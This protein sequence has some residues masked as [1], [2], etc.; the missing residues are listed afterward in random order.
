[1]NSLGKI[2]FSFGVKSTVQYYHSS[3]LMNLQ[4]V[5][6]QDE[7]CYHCTYSNYTDRRTNKKNDFS[8]IS[9]RLTCSR[10]EK[11]KKSHLEWKR[12]GV[13]QSLVGCFDMKYLIFNF[14]FIIKNKWYLF[15]NLIYHA[16][17]KIIISYLT[18]YYLFNLHDFINILIRILLLNHVLWFVI[19]S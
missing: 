3:F 1:V 2:F 8:Y 5:C 17:G 9:L 7:C 10:R 15:L 16:D 6:L 4:T 18:F 11:S 12:E 13:S 14:S 19:I